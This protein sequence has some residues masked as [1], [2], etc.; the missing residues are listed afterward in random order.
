MEDSNGKIRQDYGCTAFPQET[1]NLAKIN[2]ES[3]K[4]LKRGKRERKGQTKNKWE[5]KRCK[6]KTPK[7]R[8]N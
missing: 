6:K 7:T 2:E 8:N 1:V 4:S 3:S 5:K